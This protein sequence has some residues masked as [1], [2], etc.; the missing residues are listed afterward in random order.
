MSGLRKTGLF[1]KVLILSFLFFYPSILVEPRLAYPD[2]FDLKRKRLVEKDLLRHG[3]S[4]KRVLAAMAKVPRHEFVLPR[5]KSQAYINQALPIDES[6]T[7]SQPY[8]V[9]LMTQSIMLKPGDKVLEIGTGSGYQAAVLAEIAD[10]VY[11]IEII[12]NLADK[13]GKTL[14][15]LGYKNVKVKYG[16]GYRGWKK[17]APFDAIIITAA[18]P[19]IPQPL[20]DQLKV[21]GRMVLPVDNDS[22]YQNLILMTKKKDGLNK[23]FIAGV[24]FVPMTGEVRR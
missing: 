18:A 12:K 19:V 9:A 14:K 7:I 22:S 6:Q 10:E 21:G 2:S 3:I 13:A 20:I 16:D 8:V 5:L 23:K 15:R 24:R 1:Y 4:D 11:S 17:F